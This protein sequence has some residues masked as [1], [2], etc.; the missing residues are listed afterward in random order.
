MIPTIAVQEFYV[1]LEDLMKGQPNEWQAL[2]AHQKQLP[3]STSDFDYYVK[4]RQQYIDI[5]RSDITEIE[6]DADGVPI[7]FFQGIR[8]MPLPSSNRPMP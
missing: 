6:T 4:I 3:V 1:E 7:V 5:E 2:P 8:V